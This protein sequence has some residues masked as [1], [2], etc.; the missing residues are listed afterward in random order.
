MEKEERKQEKKSND[1]IRLNVDSNIHSLI[2]T[3]VSNT[4]MKNVQGVPRRPP[5]R[6]RRRRT[7]RRK[8]RCTSI[9]F[10]PR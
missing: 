7:R 1:V 3:L 9:W 2:S 6:T 5:A 8:S 4:N 10:A